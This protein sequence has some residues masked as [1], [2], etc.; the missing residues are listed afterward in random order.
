[1]IF[2]CSTLTRIIKDDAFNKSILDYKAHKFFLDG[3]KASR[4]IL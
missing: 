2:L 3:L 1:F 4:K